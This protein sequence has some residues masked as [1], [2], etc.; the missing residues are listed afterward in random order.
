MSEKEKIDWKKTLHLPK[1]SFP[2]KASLNQKEPEMLKRWEKDKLYDKIMKERE[3]LPSFIL[4][5]GPPYANGNIHLGHALNKIL[6]DFIIKSKSMQGYKAPYVPGWDCHGLPIE[7]NIDKK[8]GKKKQDTSIEKFRELCLQYAENF[9][10]IQKEEFKRLGIIAD[11]KNP[12]KT[13]NKQYEASIIKFFRSFVEKGN[14]IRKK[15]PVYWCMDCTTALAEAE[16]EYADHASPSIYVK[17]PLIDKQG[18]LKDYENL[19]ISMLIWTTTPWTIPANLAIALHSDFTYAL[20]KCRGEY[21]IAAKELI[22]NICELIEEEYEIIKEFLGHELNG[23]KAKHPIIDRESLIINTDYVELETGTGCVHTAPGHGDDD[24]KAGLKHNL[25]I[26]SPVNSDGTFDKSVGKYAGKKVFEANEDIIKDIEEAGMLIKRVD[27]K[28]SYPHCWRCKAPVIFRATKQWFIAMDK[29]SLREKALEEIKKVKW[30]PKWGEERIN[31]MITNRPDWCISRQR[32]WGVPIPVVFCK[33]CDEP[34]LSLEII[35]NVEETFAQKGSASW[36]T[37]DIKEFLSQD[38]KCQCGCSEFKKGEDILDVWFESGASFGILNKRENHQFP[39]DIYLE[40]G[41]QYRGW[42]HS[43][44][45]ISVMAREC[46]PYK[47]VI[48]HGWTLDK[49]G[50]AMS[51]SLGNTIKPQKIIQERGAEVLRLWIAFVNYREDIRVSGEILS[52]VSETYRKIRNTWRFMLGVIADFSMDENKVL[53]SDLREVDLYILYRLEKIKKSIID[54][55]ENFEYHTI[56]HTLSNFF[57]NDLS[58]FYLHILKDHLYCDKKDSISRRAAQT[59]TYKIL[60]ETILLMAPILSFTSEEA[61]GYFPEFEGKKES[62]HMELFPEYE[63]NAEEKVDVDRWDTILTLRDKCLKVIEEAREKKVLGDSLEAVLSVTL[64]KDL[65]EKLKNDTDLFKE[66][67]VIS[68]ITLEEG[69]EE[70]I[71]LN[72][73]QGTKC[74]R[75]WNWHEEKSEEENQLCSRCADVAGDISFEDK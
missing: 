29:S 59:V 53:D 18:T 31:N 66:I 13:V 3:G 75:C 58:A 67:L 22:P 44:L 60:K 26:Y 21:Y 25:D 30:L 7:I 4:H 28:H 32:S 49:N 35:D 41:D 73:S 12:Y 56:C 11:W 64:T 50:R 24:Y 72:K 54:S 61:W 6:K 71:T 9:V 5:D 46:S 1:T 52:R 40:G 16:V 65:Y 48:T 45:L 34:L 14:I 62:V 51:K 27:I 47:Q 39:A 33:D 74:P 17:F 38:S 55:Y 23:F 70:K 8:L 68:K 57:I 37:K 2:M 20:F 69:S 63:P 36:Y 10:N 19:D 42:F 43:S 15:K